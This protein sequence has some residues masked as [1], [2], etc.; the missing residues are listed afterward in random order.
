V[1][2]TIT[3]RRLRA[4]AIARSL[5]S[6][7]S[8]AEAVRRLG[9]VQADP[10]RA[11]ARA[12][13][14]TLRHRVAGYRAG[15]LERAYPT[16]DV[17]E[18]FFLNY[19]FLP[20][21]HLALLHPRGARAWDRASARRA[22]AVLEVVRELGEAHPR[23]VGARFDHGKVVNYWGGTSNATTQLL[24]GMHYRGLVRVARRDAGIRVYAAR[25]EPL[26]SGLPARERA[27]RLLATAIAKYAPVPASGVGA[28][29]SRLRWGSPA[30][31]SELKAAAK[32][33]L[34]TLPRARCEGVDFVWPEG[35]DPARAEP[36]DRA[37][38]LA[39]FDPVVWDRRRFELFWGWAYRF[40]AYTPV[41]KRKLGYY[42][43]PLAWRDE[44]V[45]WANVTGEGGREVAL[46]WASGAPP[47]ARAFRSALEEEIESLRAFL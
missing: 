16:L 41:K 35:E 34:A 28:L 19:G 40:E 43:L 36:L 12:Q 3:L 27:E 22:S 5:F 18:D 8:L 2:R 9:F 20:R 42:A 15:D 17:D 11:P 32:R 39:P 47:R 25:A 26:D 46:G 6:P 30:L 21:D 37:R 14:L 44:V 31:A 38:L 23:D 29:A 1:S 45:G 10:I 33:A 13:D 24:D 7:T 4:H